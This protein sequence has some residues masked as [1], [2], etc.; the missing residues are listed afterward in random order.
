MTRECWIASATLVLAAML[1]PLSVRAGQQGGGYV[2]A[3]LG[4]S[5]VEDLKLDE[6]PGAIP[7]SHVK[8][9]PGVRM[10]FGGGYRFN[11]WLKL[12]GE[13]G[14][15]A[16]KVQD[17]DVFLSQVPFMGNIELRLPNRSP[18]VPFIGGGPG[19]SV[20]TIDFHDDSLGSGVRLDGADSEAVFAW[21]AY[22]GVRIK[23][24]R[25]MSIGVIYKYYE[26][27]STRWEVEDTSTDIRF[28]RIRTHA[29]AVTFSMDF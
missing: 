8:F 17:A 28:G 2:D 19:F 4:G 25:Q 9:E 16:N 1:S 27:N 26:A 21:Q 18:F 11:D 23:L 15:I 7:G 13:T 12:G 29:A 20:N 5:V 22:A 6:F 3:D 10:S 24:N 14:V